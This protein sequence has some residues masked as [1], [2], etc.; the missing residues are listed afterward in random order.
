LGQLTKKRWIRELNKK[1]KINF[2][3]IQE[4]KLESIDL[5][6]IKELRGDFNEVR[7][8]HERFGTIFNDSGAKSFNHIISTPGLIDLPREGYSYTWA[9]KSASKMSKLDRF[10]A[11]EGCGY[12]RPS[13]FRV[14][15]SW[16]AKDRFD[17]L[18]DDSWNNLNFSNSSKITL[19]RKKFQALKALIKAWCK[20]D[21]Q[22]SSE[23]CL[24][25]K[26]RI[27]DLD[28]M[29]NNGIS[30]ED[31]VNERTSLLK[32]L[33]NINMHHS[34]DMAQ[35]AKIRW[36]I[37]GDE[38]L[39]SSMLSTEQNAYLKCDVSYDEIKRAV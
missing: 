25:I 23:Y 20:D 12:Y 19:L 35:K 26:S 30:N 34:L 29:F 13:P 27:S 9:I 37:E 32:D 22:R 39:N 36:S 38:I 15:H 24:S 1:N 28:K 2:A 10:L 18:V 16:F 33:H 31:L 7:S 5:F 6:S 17:K 11:S 3:A 4:T 14:Y 21:K 8:K